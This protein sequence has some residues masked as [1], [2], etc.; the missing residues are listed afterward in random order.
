MRENG[1]V[2]LSWLDVLE[3][4]GGLGET[5]RKRMRRKLNLLVVVEM[6]GRTSS[7][8]PLVN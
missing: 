8:L 5:E 4:D 6:K 1:L 2:F 3:M 7:Q